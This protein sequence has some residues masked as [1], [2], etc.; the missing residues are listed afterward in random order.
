M[1]TYEPKPFLDAAPVNALINS[2]AMTAYL[3]T[4]RENKQYFKKGH[5]AKEA[6]KLDFI[7]QHH[8]YTYSVINALQCNDVYTM[9]RFTATGEL[10]NVFSYSPTYLMAGGV[11]YVDGGISCKGLVFHVYGGQHYYWWPGVTTIASM[12]LSLG[13]KAMFA[14]YYTSL[15]KARTLTQGVKVLSYSYK[16]VDCS[17]RE[18]VQQS[19]MIDNA[20]IVQSRRMSPHAKVYKAIQSGAEV[21][22]KVDDEFK[23]IGKI[24]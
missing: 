23:P 2:S 3:L 24:H 21:Y 14:E 6:A 1:I 22:V 17:T 9:C 4:V 10:T 15:T 11:S 12:Y 19:P 18:P 7:V 16:D 13:H 20:I 5:I 8:K